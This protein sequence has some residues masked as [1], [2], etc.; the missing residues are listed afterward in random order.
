MEHE[1]DAWLAN[2]RSFDKKGEGAMKNDA[3][4]L[5]S[6]RLAT[7]SDFRLKTITCLDTSNC[8]C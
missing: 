7:S 4:L 2:I 5:E 1:L 6:A 8:E 3:I